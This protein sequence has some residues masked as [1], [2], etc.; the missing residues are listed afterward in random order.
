MALD[1]MKIVNATSEFPGMTREEIQ[2][3]LEN[4]LIVMHL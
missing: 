3:F 1:D 2:R 4:K